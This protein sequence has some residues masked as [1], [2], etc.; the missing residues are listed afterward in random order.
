MQVFQDLLIIRS[1]LP[2]AP[3]RIRRYLYLEDRVP[4]RLYLFRKHFE[5]VVVPPREFGAH[6]GWNEPAQLPLFRVSQALNA[7]YP[8]SNIF[9]MLEVSNPFLCC[10]TGR[11][12]ATP[13]FTE[14]GRAGSV[15]GTS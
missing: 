4:G 13:Y 2:I 6:V 1:V 11:T 12:N 15:V 10:E 14:G 5:V 3:E 9:R 7:H 8:D